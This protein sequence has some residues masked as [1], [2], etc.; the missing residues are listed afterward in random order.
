[1]GGLQHHPISS[2]SDLVA[3]A[4]AMTRIRPGKIER[5]GGSVKSGN[6]AKP[7]TVKP[8]EPSNQIDRR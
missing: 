4:F 6:P 5:N 2:V 1:M 8:D 7:S 3:G